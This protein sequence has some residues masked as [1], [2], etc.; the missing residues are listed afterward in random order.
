MRASVGADL[1]HQANRASGREQIKQC[2]EAIENDGGLPMPRTDGEWAS[3]ETQCVLRLLWFC[4]ALPTKWIGWELD[5]EGKSPNPGIHFFLLIWLW[6]NWWTNQSGKSTQPYTNKSL[7]LRIQTR[8]KHIRR[9]ISLRKV[10]GDKSFN[11]DTAAK[12]IRKYFSAS[13]LQL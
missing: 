8:K 7:S 3:K 4:G 13:L 6:L 5:L 9:G 2:S 1:Q 11:I 12:T 10:N